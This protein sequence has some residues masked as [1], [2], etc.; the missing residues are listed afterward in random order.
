MRNRELENAITVRDAINDHR[1]S[2]YAA[3]NKKVV[4]AE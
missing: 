4:E 2:E 3:A 1:S